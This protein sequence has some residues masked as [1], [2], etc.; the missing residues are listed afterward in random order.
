MAE[1]FLGE[2]KL[3]SFD[4]IPRGWLAC[5]GALLQIRLYQALFTLVGVT[6]G[7]DGRTTFGIPDLRGRV[8]TGATSTSSGDVTHLGAAGGQEKVTLV[9]NNIPAHNHHLMVSVD[10]GNASGVAGSVYAS[11]QTPTQENMYAPPSVPM[12]TIGAN[13][14]Q[15]AGGSVAHENMQPY[16]VLTYCIAAEGIYP[17]RP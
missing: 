10:P 4:R 7:G 11:P 6:Y 3:F 1:P 9:T 14:L 5:N 8:A 13:S 15:S 2:V 16:T 12:V 17:I